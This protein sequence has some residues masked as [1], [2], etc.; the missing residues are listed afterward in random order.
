MHFISKILRFLKKQ[1]TQLAYAW[2]IVKLK[3]LYPGISI[4]FE[5][6]IESNCSI[7]C[8]KGGRLSISNSKISFGTN[9]VADAASNLVIDNC[10]IGR[11]CVITSKE[12]IVMHKCLIAEMVVIRDQDHITEIT[13]EKN[14]REKFKTA[15]IEIEENVWI[16]AK[17]TILKG[18]HIEKFAVIAASAVVTKSVPSYEVWAGIPAK[19]LKRIDTA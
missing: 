7:I 13:D 15:A 5:T 11:N 4:D 19:F 9:I 14:S 12:K 10:F 2:R 17:A 16:A 3:L 18:V 1:F 6:K 8:I